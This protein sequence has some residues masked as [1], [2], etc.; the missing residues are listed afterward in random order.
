MLGWTALVD[1]WVHVWM[2]VRED[3]NLRN[4]NNQ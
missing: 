3:G 4:T 2:A 1:S